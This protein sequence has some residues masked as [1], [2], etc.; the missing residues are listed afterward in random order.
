VRDGVTLYADV[1]RPAGEGPHPVLLMREPYDK[2]TA[3]TGSGYAHPSWWA[4]QGWVVVVQDCRGRFRSEGE[5]YPFVH[6]AEDGYDAVAWASRLSGADGRVAMYGFSYPGA[7][8]LLAANAP[9]AEPR[10]DLSRDDGLAVLRGLDVQRR[11]LR[12][13]V[14]RHLGGGT[15]IRYGAAGGRR[16]RAGRAEPGDRTLGLVLPAAA[17]RLAPLTRDNAPYFFDWLEHSSYDDYWRATC[18]AEGYERITVPGLHVGGWYDIFLSGTVENFGGLE[19][20]AGGQKLLIGPWQHGPWEPLGGAAAE[21]SRTAVNDWQLRFLDRVVKGR[22]SGVFDSPVTAYVTGDG[23]R[24]FDAWPPSSA[25]PVDYYLHSG[26]RANSVYGDGS[27]STEP[28]G[29]EPSDLFVYDP[30]APVHSVGGHSCCDESL[31]PMGPRSQQPAE[32]SGDVLVYTTSP[33]EKELDLVGVRARFRR[34]LSKPELL[35]PGRVE[36]YRIAL[37]PIGVRVPAGHR[38]RL[39]VSSS[40]FP[41]WDRNLNTGGPLG[42]E[43]AA[44]AVVAT[45][46]VRH[47][48]A[49]L[50]RLTLPVLA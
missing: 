10:R 49:H 50:S 9:A 35:T 1:Y 18:I 16:G 48:R 23:W 32:R 19:Q 13:C 14:R 24:D 44:A 40:D 5:W 31:T 22:E 7:T 15:R 11:G 20:R 26:G 17:R 46:V 38:L 29:N 39:D 27:L 25:R 42:K 8:Q 2:S 28:P 37:G 3:Q 34:S 41:H 21:A 4:G 33:L 43:G 12:A 45:Q 6:E 30:L 47:D 36:E